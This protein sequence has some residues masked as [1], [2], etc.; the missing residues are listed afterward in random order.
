MG[1]DKMKK[2][3]TFKVEEIKK[4]NKSQ[5]QKRLILL[6]KFLTNILNSK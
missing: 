2:N 4:P 5:A 6:S 3:E 1:I